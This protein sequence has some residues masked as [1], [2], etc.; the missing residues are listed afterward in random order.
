MAEVSKLVKEKNKILLIEGA[1]G[2]GKT[3][4]IGG[5]IGMIQQRNPTKKI[6]VCAPNDHS[7]DQVILR[8][9]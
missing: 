5:M 3:K 7:L 8:L 9:F 1:P 4:T 2:T 6:L